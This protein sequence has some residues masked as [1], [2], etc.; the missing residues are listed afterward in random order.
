MK[1]SKLAPA[2]AALGLAAV[3]DVADGI[4]EVGH[5]CCDCYSAKEFFE[6]SLEHYHRNPGYFSSE[7]LLKY[8]LD[9]LRAEF[10][11]GAARALGDE[12]A[13]GKAFESYVGTWDPLSVVQHRACMESYCDKDEG[14]DFLNDFV[15][16][17]MEANTPDVDW[18]SCIQAAEDDVAQSQYFP[19]NFAWHTPA[20]ERF[21]YEVYFAQQRITW[22]AQDMFWENVCYD[23]IATETFA[24]AYE[25]G[26]QVTSEDVE[27]LEYPIAQD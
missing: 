12:V 17:M 7:P 24:L 3:P 5:G 2:V 11:K 25:L 26:A 18:F 10:E 21:D 23:E 20:G 4:L 15:W 14:A 22:A 27:N 13:S 1:L 8:V 9:D 19:D 16:Y 6:E